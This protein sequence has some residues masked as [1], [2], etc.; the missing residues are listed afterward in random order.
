MDGKRNVALL[1]EVHPNPATTETHSTAWGGIYGAEGGV[2]AAVRRSLFWHVD[3]IEPRLK[4]RQHE[5]WR[6][7]TSNTT[8][9]EAT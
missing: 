2:S 6:P 7:L 1:R 9:P 4:A 5:Y 3:Q 8:A